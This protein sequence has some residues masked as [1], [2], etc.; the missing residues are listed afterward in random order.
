MRLCCL[1]RDN[2]PSQRLVITGPPLQ[3]LIG[4]KQSHTPLPFD[5]EVEGARHQRH[6]K[7]E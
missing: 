7:A 5:D 2:T 4:G 1:I 6:K 3:A